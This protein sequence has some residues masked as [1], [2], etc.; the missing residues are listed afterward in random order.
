MK[1]SIRLKLVLGLFGCVLFFFGVTILG[2]SLFL[3]PYYTRQKEAALTDNFE[4]ITSMRFDSPDI[5]AKLRQLEE[6]EN[7]QI[8]IID[9]TRTVFFCSTRWQDTVFLPIEQ[10]R[11]SPESGSQWFSEWLVPEEDG[12][13]SVEIFTTQPKFGKRYN[14]TLAAT[15]LSLY[16]KANMQYG[17]REYPFYIIIN[18][19]NAAIEDGVHIANRFALIV[20]VLTLIMAAAVAMIMGTRLS[21]P[22]KLINTT[23]KKMAQL[24]FGERLLIDSHDEMTEL[25]DSIN[26][27]SDQL[28]TKINELSVANMQ[29]RQQLQH[30]ER[31]DTMRRDFISD[32]SHELKTPLSIIL[33]YCEG[34]QLNVNSSER[35]YYCSVIEDE[36][37]RMS[38]VASR[39][40]NLAELESGESEPVRSFFDLGELARE[41]LEKLSYL[42]EERGISHE[43]VCEGA[44]PVCADEERIEEVINNLLSNA[45]N[46]TPDGGKI[47]V[48][49]REDGRD[50]VTCEVR[51]SG[52]HVPEDS[53]DKIWESFYKVDKA[54]TRA[55]GGSGLGLKIVSTILQSHGAQYG[56]ENTEDGVRFFFT[57]RKAEESAPEA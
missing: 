5:D 50:G 12:K 33:G 46:H 51:N 38:R 21:K 52:S 56:V 7:I 57:L 28:E 25:A 48:S 53:L 24:D 42:L 23:A 37:M 35:E 40:L 11:D 22:V 3:Q 9:Y 1:W 31:I 6:S 43:F 45:R 20:G 26:N 27:L 44:M 49:V 17:S 47:R 30:K 15:Y 29:L 32:V 10:E 16:A 13:G 41:R 39:L 34:L 4:K 54:R 8:L 19:S 14:S 55:Y 36:A 2:N 18:T